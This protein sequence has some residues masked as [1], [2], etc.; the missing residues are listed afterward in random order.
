MRHISRPPPGSTAALHPGVGRLEGGPAGSSG[1]PAP[2]ALRRPLDVEKPSNSLKRFLRRAPR[3]ARS[4]TASCFTLPV[5]LFGSPARAG[6]QSAAGWTTPS[7]GD[8]QAYDHFWL[9]QRV[10]AGAEFHPG[11]TA[12][13]VPTSGAA[14]IDHPSGVRNGPAAFLLGADGINSRVR[15]AL[16]KRRQYRRAPLPLGSP[17]AE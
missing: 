10:D 16:F 3:S 15:R 1:F 6:A 2:Q 5:E 17:R 13:A 9:N 11:S 7:S 14:K 4:R 8:R 12:V